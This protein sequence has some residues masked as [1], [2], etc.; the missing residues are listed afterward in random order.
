M[1]PLETVQLQNKGEVAWH[2]V[3]LDLSREQELKPGLYDMVASFLAD[4]PSC[5]LCTF[6]Y[7]SKHFPILQNI[8]GY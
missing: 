1:C 4:K 3:D 7:I 2:D 6:R 5:D 8:A